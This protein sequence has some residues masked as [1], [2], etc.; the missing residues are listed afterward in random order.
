MNIN[1]TVIPGCAEITPKP[2]RDERG[3]F[4]KTF[5]QKLFSGL[6]LRTAF[7]EEYYSWSRHR[8]LRGLHFQTPPHDHVK[9]VYC[10]SGSV[11]DV[12]LDVRTGSPTYGR[13][14]QVELS[15]DKANMLYIPSGLAHGFYVTG[16]HAIMLYKVTTEYSPE[17]DSGIRWDSA[18]IP[19]PDAHPIISKRDS[20]FPGL[21]D[22]ASP[23]TFQ[24]ESGS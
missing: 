21:T 18:G 1:H 12:V 8:V 9:L 15:A 5:Q 13:H 7:A 2:L 24:R 11:I 6:G 4:V 14:V 19:W 16:D 3:S 10:V 20:A 17:H 22:F 23:F